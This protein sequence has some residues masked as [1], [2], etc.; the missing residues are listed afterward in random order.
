[1]WKQWGEERGRLKKIDTSF[2][3]RRQSDGTILRYAEYKPRYHSEC[4]RRDSRFENK[5]VTS[6]LFLIFY[7]TTKHVAVKLQI[8]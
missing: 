6:E 5:Q 2:T 4:E 7:H 8:Q 3:L 1:M